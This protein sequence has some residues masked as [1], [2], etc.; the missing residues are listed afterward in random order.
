MSAPHKLISPLIDHL[1]SDGRL[2]VWSVVIT[3]FGDAVQPHGGT[4]A[5]A[6]L[7]SV[8]GHMGVESGALRTAMSRL[9][10]E[11]WVTRERQ[12]RN[13]FYRLSQAGLKS[14][15]PATEK[16][17]RAQYAP[18]PDKLIFAVGPD[19]IGT[20]REQ[21]NAL[22][23]GF[24]GMSLRNGVALFADPSNHLITQLQQA[25][26]LLID[27]SLDQLPDW[28]AEKLELHEIETD[29]QALKRRFT[30]LGEQAEQLVTLSPIDALCARILLIHEWRRLIL[31]QPPL[32]AHLLPEDWPGAAAHHLVSGLY[33]RLIEPSEKWWSNGNG[34]AADKILAQRF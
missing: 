20:A 18:T 6:D 31:K 7:Q 15:I 32:P 3:I 27:A 22:L 23:A 28:V 25:D 26:L 33:R 30:P 13:S 16:I 34:A 8:L 5:M 19:V 2:R 17:Y 24:G 12:G 9:A 14:F 21:Q 29:Y 4:V 11:G 1:H 10:K